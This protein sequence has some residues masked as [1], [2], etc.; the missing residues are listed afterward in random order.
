ML[1][2]DCADTIGTPISDGLVLVH[3]FKDHYSLQ[4]S[5]EMTLPGEHCWNHLQDRTL[6]LDAELNTIITHFLSTT[7]DRLT[8]EQ[9][10]QKYPQP[11]ESS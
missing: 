2:L 9:W 8:K 10:L 1:V 11:T 4:A 6:T 5:E 7:G 3:E